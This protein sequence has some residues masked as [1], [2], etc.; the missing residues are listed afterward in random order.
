MIDIINEPKTMEL[1]NLVIGRS[2]TLNIYVQSGR[3]D[4][5]SSKERPIG[6]A[7]GSS[8]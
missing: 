4:S 8:K 7:T 1:L 2:G 5:F 6:S 3:R